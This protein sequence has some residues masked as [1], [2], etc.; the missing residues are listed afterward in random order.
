MESEYPMLRNSV[1]NAFVISTGPQRII[2]VEGEAGG[3]HCL[4]ISSSIRLVNP[5]H[6]VDYS[7]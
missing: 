6:D 5:F 1:V 2:F 7:D 3:K 4:I